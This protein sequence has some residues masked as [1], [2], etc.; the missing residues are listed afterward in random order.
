MS[1]WSEKKETQDQRACKYE[2]STGSVANR[3]GLLVGMKSTH[4][5]RTSK[6]IFLEIMKSPEE[7]VR[8]TANSE[9]LGDGP[10]IHRASETDQHWRFS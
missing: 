7:A 4:V 9:V 1:G 8:E 5:S 10:N 3:V 6:K 2:V